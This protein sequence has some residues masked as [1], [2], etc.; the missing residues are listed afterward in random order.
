MPIVHA[1]WLVS[2]GV[3]ATP[4]YSIFNWMLAGV[5]SQ[6]SPGTR[7]GAQSSLALGGGGFYNNPGALNDEY[8][9]NYYLDAGTFKLAFIY[10]KTSASPIQTFKINGSSVGTIDEYNGSTTYNNYS[11]ITGITVAAGQQPVQVISASRNGSSSGYFYNDQ[12]L[13]LI[14]TGA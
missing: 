1:N 6:T 8:T 9:N 12:S 4:G 14:W 10:I 2:G 5:Y 3:I 7:A 11:E 13:A